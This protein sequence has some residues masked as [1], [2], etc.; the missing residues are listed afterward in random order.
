MAGLPHFV[1]HSYLQSQPYL[2]SPPQSLKQN[3][4]KFDALEPEMVN[5]IFK[6]CIIP[7]FGVSKVY[8]FQM[9]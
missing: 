9:N 2:L 5:K 8:Y 7:I 4:Y 1:R 6:L 3:F